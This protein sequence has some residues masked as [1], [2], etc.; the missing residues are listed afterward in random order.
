MAFSTPR[1]PQRT[2]R[3]TLDGEE[4][5]EIT[6]F[7]AKRVWIQDKITFLSTTLP[8]IVVDEPAPPLLSATT[9]EQLE[10]WWE[11]HETIEKEVNEYDYGDLT[12]MRNFA[13]QKSKQELSRRDTD[14]I[15]VCLTTI[16]ALD[17]LLSLLG[18]RRKSLVL[19]GYRLQ[20]EESLRLAWD[21]RRRL[22]EEE[23][24]SFLSKSRFVIPQSLSSRSR[25][26]SLEEAQDS[27]L[28][29][30]LSKSLSSSSTSRRLSSLA[31]PDH[32]SSNSSQSSTSSSMSRTLHLQMLQLSLSQLKSHLRQLSST[33][34]QS[35]STKLDKLIDHSPEPLPETFLDEQDRIEDTIRGEFVTSGLTRVFEERV[36]A[37][38]LG[39]EMFWGGV[40]AEKGAEQ[41]GEEVEEETR[42]LRVVDQLSAEQQGR[43]DWVVKFE[44]RIKT[45]EEDLGQARRCFD[46]KLEGIL[47]SSSVSSN[48]T[49]GRLFPD[50]DEEGQ[51]TLKTLEKNLRK[52]Q[53]V[54]EE[55]RKSV[56]KF[57]KGVEAIEGAGIVREKL[58]KA[59]RDLHSTRDR[60]ERL[61]RP[62]R[63][64]A[65]DWVQSLA[66]FE[67]E[68]ADDYETQFDD[69][70]SAFTTVPQFENIRAMVKAGVRVVADLGTVGIDS[71]SR[72]ELKELIEGVEEARKEVERSKLLEATRRE[73]L[74]AVKQLLLRL[75]GGKV[76]VETLRERMRAEAARVRWVVGKEGVGSP[77]DIPVEQSTESIRDSCRSALESA[78]SV[79]AP[80]PPV[81]SHFTKLATGLDQDFDSLVVFQDA[82][83]RTRAQFEAVVAFDS[84]VRPIRSGLQAISQ[85]AEASRQ[86]IG[87]TSE[88]LYNTWRHLVKQLEHLSSALSPLVSDVHL[89][90]PF[91][92]AST[93]SAAAPERSLDK[94]VP[95]DVDE[96][97]DA[98]K[99]YLNGLIVRIK[100]EQ[101][102]AGKNIDS[103][104][105]ASNVVC[106]N[107]QRGVLEAGLN[108]LQAQVQSYEDSTR[109]L[110]DP[111]EGKE[112]LH[113]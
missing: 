106:W 88:E 13:K 108:R 40:K 17:K 45:I 61:G 110:E 44:K 105:A 75:E 67:R 74:A 11:E 35:T 5:L 15:E 87:A 91:L 96:Q 1:K 7:A 19:L 102:Q 21:S 33:L 10:K 38:R 49:I 25:E 22:L 30:P 46:S 34:L 23:I 47:A 43:T 69:A 92:S 12:K 62:R 80:F 83:R 97:D 14:L 104:E 81:L 18:Q 60:I 48:S 109:H 107:Q 50:L 86:E 95:F 55:T 76:E 113:S 99:T 65:I 52:A 42:K 77:V 103:L 54:V 4:V 72:R 101:E 3:D 94:L 39:D 93:T 82:V 66:D 29:A 2:Q 59:M 27:N 51:Q 71:N 58:R 98:V 90:I 8:R 24:P 32:F 41:L 53:V 36:E 111:S 73:R 70:L 63:D 100:Q 28:G 64:I 31:D 89:R 68:E 37:W 6:L 78:K 84:D 112:F 56:G 57:R 9:K 79:L 85:E 26:V 16:F 20:W